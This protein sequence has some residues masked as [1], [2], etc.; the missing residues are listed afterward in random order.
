[1]I[2]INIEKELKAYS[3]HQWL[4]VNREFALRAVRRWENYFF[5]GN[6]RVGSA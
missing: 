4:K 5:E 3:G 2:R 6:N 1:M